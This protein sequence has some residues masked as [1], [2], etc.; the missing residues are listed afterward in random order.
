MDCAQKERKMSGYTWTATRTCSKCD[1]SFTA[2]VAIVATKG[3]DDPDSQD[4]E[5][6]VVW[7]RCEPTHCHNCK[8]TKL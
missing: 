3:L 8:E 5:G 6:F 2:H 1:R 4:P 7:W